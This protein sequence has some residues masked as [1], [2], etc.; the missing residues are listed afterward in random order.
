MERACLV[1]LKHKGLINL[2]FSFQDNENIYFILDLVKGGDFASFLN[3][4]CK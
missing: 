3:L 2:C 4:N 1:N